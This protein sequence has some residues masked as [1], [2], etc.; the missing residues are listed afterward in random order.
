MTTIVAEAGQMYRSTYTVR[1]AVACNVHLDTASTKRV[2]VC[3][4]LHEQIEYLLAHLGVPQA[5]AEQ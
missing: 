1:P 5:V 3:Q 2:C 4:H